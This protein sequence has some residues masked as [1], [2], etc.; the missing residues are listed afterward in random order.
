MSLEYLKNWKGS[1]TI[2]G[3]DYISIAEASKI[4]FKAGQILAV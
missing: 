1:V 2:N 3:T 4:N